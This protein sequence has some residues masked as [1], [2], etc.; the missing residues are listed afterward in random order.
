MN[1]SKF[2]SAVRKLGFKRAWEI[3]N[4]GS[5]VISYDDLKKI[6]EPVIVCY[7]GVHIVARDKTR[8]LYPTGQCYV[9]YEN[10][11]TDVT[12]VN[13]MKK[14]SQFSQSCFSEYSKNLNE[15][16]DRMK[17]NDSGYNEVVIKKIYPYKGKPHKYYRES[18]YN[19]IPYGSE[20]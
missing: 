5:L 14:E 2:W 15:T 12:D 11:L 3:R 7:R 13:N 20:E 1:L 4:D 6:T 19:D 18:N 8:L 17:S 9:S 16:V 10:F